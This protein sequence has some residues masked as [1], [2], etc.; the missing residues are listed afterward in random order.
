MSADGAKELIQIHHNNLQLELQTQAW[1]FFG[2]FFL[3]VLVLFMSS[4]TL[5]VCLKGQKSQSCTSAVDGGSFLW[6]FLIIFSGVMVGLSSIDIIR[7]IVAIYDSLAF[8][9]KT[10]RSSRDAS[11]VQFTSSGVL[12]KGARR[13]EYK[14]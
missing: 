11:R 4:L 10:A 13:S 12:S 5:R 1:R 8:K 2:Y 6:N 9:N 7:R 14:N 3:G